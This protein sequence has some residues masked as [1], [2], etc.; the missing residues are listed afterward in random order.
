ML[1]LK[2]S[3]QSLLLGVILVEEREIHVR[4]EIQQEE[5]QVVFRQGVARRDRLLKRTKGTFLNE[6]LWQD[7]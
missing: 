3:I 7:A 5:H 1:R 2:K 6:L 4:D